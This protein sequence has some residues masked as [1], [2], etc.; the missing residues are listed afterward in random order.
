MTAGLMLFSN[1]LSGVPAAA[2]ACRFG[3]AISKNKEYD[4]KPRYR[5]CIGIRI[6]ALL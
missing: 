3:F 2:E 6:D 4:A 5:N 1:S